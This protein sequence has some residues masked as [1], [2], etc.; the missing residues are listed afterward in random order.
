MA[1]PLPVKIAPSVLA[2]DFSNLEKETR[3]VLAKGADWV[4]LDVM[5]G[6]FVPNISFG[7]PVIKSLRKN[8][9][10]AFFDAHLM[11]SEPQRWVKELKDAGADMFTFH[12]EACKDD[13][14][15][16][17]L[18]KEIQDAGMKC[19][20]A[21]KP[22]T[23]WES[24]APCL[25]RQPADMILVMTVE[26]GFGGQKFMLDMMPKVAAARAAF[27]N[28]DIQV[29]GGLDSSNAPAAGQAGANVIVA[30]TSVFKAPCRETAI[31]Q[32]RNN[33]SRALPTPQAKID[34]GHGAQEKVCSHA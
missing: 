19:G 34:A 20:V 28:V 27:P 16:C 3:D 6:H 22:G 33:C 11:V 30:G 14:A 17:A 25:A 18:I 12:Y 9:P 24:L 4:H 5:D 32:I 10:D 26:P 31:A 7:F 1:A 29:D 8:I 13:D 15:V 23:P 2:S 21:L